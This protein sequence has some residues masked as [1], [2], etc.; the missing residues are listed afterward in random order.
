MQSLET[1]IRAL[2]PSEHYLPVLLLLALIGVLIGA[3][4]VRKWKKQRTSFVVTIGIAVLLLI[5]MRSNIFDLTL[6]NAIRAFI[7]SQYYLPVVLLL[8]LIILLIAASFVTKW[9]A[10]RPNFF[11]IMVIAI[12]LLIVMRSDVADRWSW[13]LGLVPTLLVAYQAFY[14]W[15]S[16]PTQ[17]QD[18]PTV[19][20]VNLEPAKQRALRSVYDQFAVRALFFRYGFPA[21]LL[22]II[23]I[24][25]LNVMIRP[26]TF[27]SLYTLFVSSPLIVRIADRNVE[28]IVLGVRLG[29]IG[30]YV[31]VLLQLG[32][33]T[34]RHD[35]TGASAMWCLVTLVLGPLLAGTVALLWHI[36]A[37]NAQVSNWWPGGVVLF[38]TGYAPRR[39]ILAIEQAAVQLLNL[40]GSGVVPTRLIPLTQIRGISSQIEE[41]LSEEGIDDANALAAAEP[42]RLFRNTSFDFRQILTWIDEAILIVT[43]PRGWQGLEEEGITG[44]IDLAS[45]PYG[46]EAPL[47]ELAP[48]A[49]VT[50]E[51][52]AKALEELAKKANLSTENLLATIQRFR[53]DQQVL[54]IWALYNNF[55]EASGSSGDSDAPSARRDD[56]PR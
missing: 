49:A 19:N 4:F 56:S 28:R 39:V 44:A 55:T 7:P 2:I 50:K 54:Y 42:I 29:A 13:M 52:Q 11:V 18:A 45:Y 8:L 47:A 32:R 53:E 46:Y 43:L 24:V 30:A 26:G 31:Y 6:K 40:G 25:I 12:L 22:C 21:A 33:R 14:L 15:L 10:Q 3:Y 23:G 38:F 16:Q 41:R 5:L 48:I 17:V 37:P 51:Q 9:E 36:D 34:F 1:A 27:L 35:V 20:A